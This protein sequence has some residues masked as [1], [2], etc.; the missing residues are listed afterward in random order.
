[1]SWRSAFVVVLLCAGVGRTEP[2]LDY[3]DGRLTAR[4]DQVPIADVLAA[5]A[6]ATGATIRG[7]VLEPRE[8]TKHF[9]DLPIDRAVDRLLGRQ[10]F[11][12]RYDA[13]RQPVTLRRRGWE[14]FA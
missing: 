9:E 6:E 8:V 7:E 5:L 1:M 13:A 12:L 4:L 10:N 3:A 2:L 14:H 11:T